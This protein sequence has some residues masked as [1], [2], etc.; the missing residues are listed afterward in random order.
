MRAARIALLLALLL[1]GWRVWQRKAALEL[2]AVP[3]TANLERAIERDEHNADLF[4]RLG[5]L[6]RDELA[7]RD[8]E[9]ARR[10]MERA[11]E[12]RPKSA[13]FRAEMG[14]LYEAMG[15][16][17]EAEATLQRA[18]D[19]NP[20]DAPY[21]WRLANL[22]LRLGANEEAVALFGEAM[23]H[24]RSLVDAG[25]SLLLKSGIDPATVQQLWPAGPGMAGQLLRHLLRLRSRAG[26]TVEASILDQQWAWALADETAPTASQASSY[27][28]YLAETRRYDALRGAWIAH[29]NRLGIEDAAY[30]AG[31]NAIW[32]G[33]FGRE[34]A[35]GLMGWRVRKA[36]EWL[37]ERQ[38][39]LGTD[40][41]TAL[42]VDFR[43]AK[44]NFVGLQQQLL[45][46][47]GT[48]YLL[49]A[50]VASQA[51][52]G[53]ELYL[54]VYDL[55][56]RQQLTRL[57]LGRGT[58]DWHGVAGAFGPLE[59]SGL[60]RLT[61]RAEARR[62]AGALNGRLLLGKLA[63]RPQPSTPLKP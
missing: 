49:S 26:L 29:Q 3:T 51:L 58:V 63:I 34:F 36:E 14:A 61:L 10:H 5:R 18:V 2:A 27:L 33:D 44:G 22:K 62:G 16:A 30:S 59:I 31:H 8:H 1:A 20:R 12:L 6:E 53:P 28:S 50:E 55:A 32:N 41:A 52:E 39:R 21:L 42:V 17:S 9:K 13:H 35:A 56:A 37:I 43:D 57:P 19:L 45:A 54:E 7:A 15:L 40:G 46:T 60:L 48:H 24:D 23:A 4:M 25:A 38:D 11:V 47:A